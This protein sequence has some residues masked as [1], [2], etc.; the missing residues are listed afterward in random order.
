MSR[1]GRWTL[2]L[3]VAIAA[4]APGVSEAVTYS[5]DQLYQMGSSSYRQQAWAD[6]ARYLF[7]YLQRNPSAL[8]GNPDLESQVEECMNFALQRIASTITQ[9]AQ[10]HQ[11]LASQNTG[12]GNGLGMTSSG[13]TM[14]PPALPELT[15]QPGHAAGK[16]NLQAIKKPTGGAPVAKWVSGHGPDEAI[17]Y[18]IECVQSARVLD[19]SKSAAS[20]RLCQTAWRG[21]ATQSWRFIAL[22]DADR[23]CYLIEDRGTGQVL[24]ADGDGSGVEL[25]A[26]RMADAAKWRLFP[27]LDGSV[28]IVGKTSGRALDVANASL[29]DG[30]PVNQYPRHDGANQR[31]FLVPAPQ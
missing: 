27:T 8:A 26:D 14:E 6:A 11:Q 23:G 19:L 30:A 7:A 5:D 31:W 2:W 25:S 12:G 17:A 3:A 13:I 18:R 21:G 20:L 9:E 24:I 22:R 28:V 4:A 16:F 15:S 29:D 10:E 1:F